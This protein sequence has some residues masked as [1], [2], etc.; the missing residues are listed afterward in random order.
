MKST[1]KTGHLNLAPD[2]YNKMMM[3]MTVSCHQFYHQKLETSIYLSGNSSRQQSE[4]NAELLYK[5][6]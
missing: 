1:I 4:V 3:M 5:L 2:Y 6:S